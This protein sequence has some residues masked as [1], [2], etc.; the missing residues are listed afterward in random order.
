MT[1]YSFTCTGG[2]KN[3]DRRIEVDSAHAGDLEQETLTTQVFGFWIYLMS[4]LLLF[5]GD[6][7]NLRGP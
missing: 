6:L 1:N 2:V 3:D 5:F 4:D 7:C